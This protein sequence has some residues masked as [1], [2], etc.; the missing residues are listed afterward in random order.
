MGI[1]WSGPPIHPSHQPVYV[2]DKGPSPSAPPYYPPQPQLQQPPYT[3]AVH[4]QQQQLHTTP[5]PQQQQMYAY[6]QTQPQP[7]QQQIGTGTAILGG[8]MIGAI[9]EEMLDPADTY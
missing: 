4:Y 1:C 2:V 5:Y 6:Y 7:Q 3:Y 8:C 9:I